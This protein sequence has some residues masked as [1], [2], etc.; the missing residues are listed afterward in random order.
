MKTRKSN[1]TIAVA[2]AGFFL[3]VTIPGAVAQEQDWEFEVV[4]YMWAAG[5]GGTTASGGDIDI[6]FDDI[7]DNLDIALMS[8]FEARKGKWSFL[9]DV[10]Y[11]DLDN[12]SSTLDV[13]MQSWIVTPALGYNLIREENFKLDIL[14]GA[15]FLWLK[16]EVQP[17]GGPRLSDSGDV[18]DGIVGLKGELNL[19]KNWS[20]P[21]C[22]DV[23]A[24][25][26]NSTWQA[27]GGLAYK[28]KK[29]DVLMG[30]RY[31]DWDFDDN[32]VFSDLNISG[33]YAGIKI[34][35]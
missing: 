19:S 35:F 13:G 17:A 2:L 27:M 6:G 30:Y 12:D 32:N 4:P 10:I 11:M 16:A 29:C 14:G 8:T 31:L 34:P 22:L 25:N 1:I 21:F 20:M 7:L 28:L 26:S 5:I 24:G 15:R 9:T 23:G 3:L 33:P 18:W